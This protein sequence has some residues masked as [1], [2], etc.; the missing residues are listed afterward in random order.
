[1]RQ[2]LKNVKWRLGRTSHRCML[3]LKVQ[4]APS[5]LHQQGGNRCF[6]NVNL[7]WS[8]VIGYPG[9]QSMDKIQ[10]FRLYDHRHLAVLVVQLLRRLVVFTGHCIFIQ[11]IFPCSCFSV[12]GKS[13]LLIVW[14]FNY[15]VIINA[16]I[17]ICYCYDH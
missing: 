11:S 10:H 12:F 3:L 13:S 6:W 16:S 4:L 9:F 15:F 2:F 7:N 14:L 17:W 1:M 8:P 5:I